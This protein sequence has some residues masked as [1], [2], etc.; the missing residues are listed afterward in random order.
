MGHVH[1]TVDA[2]KAGCD[3]QHTLQNMSQACLLVL[4]DMD[5]YNPHHG[6]AR[7]TF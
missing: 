6:R 5:G 3:M 2:P 7:A 4:L 1:Y